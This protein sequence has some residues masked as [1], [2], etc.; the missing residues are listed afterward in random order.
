[1]RSLVRAALVFLALLFSLY[2]DPRLLV[3]SIKRT[4]TLPIDAASVA[5][6]AGRLPERP[7]EIERAVKERLARYAVPWQSY[8]VPW[9]IATPAESLRA[10]VADCEGQTVLLASLLEAKNIPYRVMASVDHMWVD[11]PGRPTNAAENPD[12]AIGEGATGRYRVRK[13]ASFDWRQSL[14]IEVDYFWRAMP[15]WRRWL[16]LAAVLLALCIPL[17][18][19]LSD[20]RR[21][22]SS[23]ALHHPLS[24][25][26]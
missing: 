4:F 2:P 22:L 20:W 7:A 25:P 21:P 10:G 5:E 14:E 11:Y 17:P 12:V 15:V 9:Y 8:G 13:P 19:G 1:M 24:S 6:V 26:S 23:G 3:R 16:T 18:R